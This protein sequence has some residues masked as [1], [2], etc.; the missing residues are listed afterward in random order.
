MDEFKKLLM[1]NTPEAQQLALELR[2]L[3]RRLLPKAKEKIYKGWGVADHGFGE[4]GRGLISIGPQKKYVN[5]YFMNGVDLTDP[6]HL[7]EGTGKRLRHVKIRK[8]DEL[9]SKAL[10]ALIRSAMK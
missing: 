8:S 9:K 7:L 5:L 2:G 4:F 3:I 1:T 10:H 6:E